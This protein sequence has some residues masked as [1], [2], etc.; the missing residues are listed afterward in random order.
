MTKWELAKMMGLSVELDRSDD[1]FY[2][3]YAETSSC[4]EKQVDWIRA[5]SLEE[6]QEK[7]AQEYF[8]SINYKCFGRS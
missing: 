1:R 3:A 6:A 7:A 5:D 2:Y 4:D 8:H